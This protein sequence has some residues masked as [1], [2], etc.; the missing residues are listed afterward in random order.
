MNASSLVVIARDEERCLARALE[1]AAPYVDELLVLDTGSTDATVEIALGCGAR[2]EHFPW[3][4]DFAAARNRALELASHPLRLVLDADE[5]VESGGEALARWGAVNPGRVGWVTRRDLVPDSSRAGVGPSVSV[6]RL[7]RVLPSDVRYEGSIHEQPVHPDPAVASGLVLG[8]DGYLPAANTAKRGR[9]E[10]LLRR[11]LAGG[12]D[13]YLSYQ[14]AKELE[15]QERYHEA[16]ES[17]LVALERTPHEAAWRHPLVVRTLHL[18]TRTERFD[19]GVAL[20]ESERTR[21]SRSPDL[22]FAAG[23]LFLQMTA[24]R[25]RD[26]GVLIELARTCWAQCLEIGDRPDLVGS[27]S[28][29]GGALAQYNLDVVS[30]VTIGRGGVQ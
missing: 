12:F 23:D 22:F 14:L 10:R 13:P 4:D 20:F 11:A 29:R 28:G 26:A 9:N 21:W 15:V 18:L 24:T 2:V 5:W 16:V 30:G 25:K 17:Y 27:V 3:C 19:E 1:S 7:V 8:H 6:E